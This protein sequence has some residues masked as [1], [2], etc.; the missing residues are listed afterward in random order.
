MDILSAWSQ[1]R[2]FQAIDLTSKV[3]CESTMKCR[4]PTLFLSLQATHLFFIN[5]RSQLA[6]SL[7]EGGGGGGDGPKSAYLSGYQLRTLWKSWH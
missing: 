4:K 5:P 3:T 6:R 2:N 1:A 7:Q